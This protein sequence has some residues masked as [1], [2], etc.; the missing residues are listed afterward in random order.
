[1]ISVA[2]PNLIPGVHSVWWW[3]DSD[4]ESCGPVAARRIDALS[5]RYRACPSVVVAR[6]QRPRPQAKRLESNCQS[7][8][9]SPLRRSTLVPS[10]RALTRGLRP[11]PPPAHG[12]T[13]RCPGCPRAA[14]VSGMR[15][16]ASS[17]RCLARSTAGPARRAADG[18]CNTRC[19]RSR[20]IRQF[21]RR[22]LFAPG[23][24][25]W[26]SCV[27]RNT[28]TVLSVLLRATLYVN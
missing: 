21:G 24:L 25:A 22:S 8:V 5:P 18:G 7:R 16:R 14:S 1:M 15:N 19:T 3:G 9:R 4:C 20:H 6:P 28:P 10:V 17:V 12:D 11:R 2:T 26:I 13:A 23:P 27:Y